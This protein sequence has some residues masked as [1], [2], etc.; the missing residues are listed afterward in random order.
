MNVNLGAPYESIIKEVISK[1][2]A[3]TQTEVI[4]QALRSYKKEIDFE[5]VYLVNK[6]V[7]HEMELIKAGNVK[8]Y[9]LEEAEKRFKK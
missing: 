2:Y 8:T 4:R 5:E 9:T 6:G 3:G 1:G 7:Q